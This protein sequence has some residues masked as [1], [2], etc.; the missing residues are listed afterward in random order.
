MTITPADGVPV[1]PSVV[2]LAVDD[3]PITI[4]SRWDDTAH[5]WVPPQPYPSW[6]WDGE[7]WQPP[8]PMPTDP[9]AWSWDEDAQEWVDVTPPE[10]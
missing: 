8:V 6:T 7:S 4:G 2:V 1:A 3:Q 10:A 5:V 9:G